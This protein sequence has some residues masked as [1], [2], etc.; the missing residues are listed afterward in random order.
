M[1]SKWLWWLIGLVVVAIIG[2]VVYFKA[3]AIN[4][5]LEAASI[6]FEAQ[7]T[8][9][10]AK[11]QQALDLVYK[12]EQQS[13]KYNTSL[14]ILKGQLLAALGR[15]EEARAQYESVK[16][17]DPSAIVAIDELLAELPTK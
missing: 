8:N 9:D 12:A 5:H 14:Q 15:V 1:K 4:Y 7:E 10:V 11:Y 13:R 6:Y 2:G 16:V 17:N 3:T